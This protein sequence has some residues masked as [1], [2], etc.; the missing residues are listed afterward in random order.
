MGSVTSF[1][2]LC[3]ANAA[4]CRWALEE[5][6]GKV[7]TFEGRNSAP[8]RVNGD[9]CV[10]KGN[11]FFVSTL[12]EK[13]TAFGGLS[14]SVGK[15]Y[16]S[17]KFAVINS[18]LYDYHPARVEMSDGF[19]GDIVQ[20]IQ[21]SC[22][23]E[24]KYINLG[25]L[26]GIKRSSGKD[27]GGTVGIQ[28]LGTLHQMLKETCPSERWEAVSRKFIAKHHETLC[29]S[30]YNAIPWFVPYW[31]GGL[32]LV[33]P[34]VVSVRDRLSVSFIKKYWLAEGE[35]CNIPTLA[36]W[37][38]HR[39]VQERLRGCLEDI[40]YKKIRH[41]LYQGEIDIQ[42]IYA[43]VYKYCTIETLFANPI[44]DLVE[45]GDPKAVSKALKEM[46]KLWLIVRQCYEPGMEPVTEEELQTQK[47][48]ENFPCIIL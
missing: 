42:D 31:A 26:Y 41:S 11:R 38:M 25:L 9:D 36:K 3:I 30:R 1:P 34:D 48:E 40:P 13:I 2:I 10:F 6:N 47:I 20:T 29:D 37:Q 23:V 12:W 24:R 4:M 16:Y 15:T 19:V 21:R 28:E 18:V 22:W 39:L 44:E 17:N 32:G 8:L 7:Y 33:T 5:A 14:S 35:S 46:Q 27:D 45:D 43:K